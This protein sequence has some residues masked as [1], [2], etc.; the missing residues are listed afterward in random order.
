MK[1]ILI[2]MLCILSVTGCSKEDSKSFEK[3][4][5]EGKVAIANQ[6]YEKA[7]NF[8]TLAKEEKEGDEELNSLYSQT[9]NLVEAIDS[10]EKKNYT[11]SI[12][13]C[14]AIHKINSKTNIVKEA[15]E[16]VKKECNELM[17]EDK[18]DKKV[19]EQTKNNST[20][21]KIS[22]KEDYTKRLAEVERQVKDL[23]NSPEFTEGSTIELRNVIGK[24]YLKWDDLLNEIYGVLKTQLSESEMSDLKNKQINW[25]KYRD[26]KADEAAAEYEGGTMAPLEYASVKVELTR[27]RCY[28]LVNK[29]M[30]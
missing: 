5:E 24:C 16:K 26:G 23:E 8:F 11:V 14:E 13:I 30:Y 28:K 12:Q 18:T 9:K 1:K 22:Q 21:T 6:E 17:K 3:Y 29:Y 19:E 2:L 20:T 10:K 27:E 25:I 4:M 7:L 15:A